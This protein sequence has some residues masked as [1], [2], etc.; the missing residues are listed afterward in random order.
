MGVI[1]GASAAGM[2]IGA[3]MATKVRVRRP[4]LVATLLTIPFALPMVLLAAHLPVPVVMAGMLIDGMASANFGVL[5]ETTIQCHIPANK[6][7]RVSSFD[8]LLSLC[9]AP[10]GLFVAGPAAALFGP[11]VVLWA[12]ALVTLLSVG[13]TLLSP[14]VRHL[15]DSIS[16]PVPRHG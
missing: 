15:T 7:S 10:V 4:M 12:W 16:N 3:L 13:L 1:N 11:E 2:V 6:L 5:W 9:L 8:I 14:S